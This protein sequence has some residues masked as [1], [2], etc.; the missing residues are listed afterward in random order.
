MANTVLFCSFLCCKNGGSYFLYIVISIKRTVVHIVLFISIA[1]VGW[2]S[3]LSS[4]YLGRGN[5]GPYCPVYIFIVVTVDPT[6]LY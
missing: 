1:G 5:V 4:I 3:L 6:V 2:W